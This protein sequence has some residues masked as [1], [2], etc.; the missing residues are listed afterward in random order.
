MSIQRW[1]QELTA[2]EALY[3]DP[4]GVWVTYDDH[5]A[6]SSGR[7]HDGYG[8]GAE[9]MRAACIAAVLAYAEER[10]TITKNPNASMD[11]TAALRVAADR[12]REV[13]P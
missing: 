11:I 2:T 5:I 1:Q 7:W 6:D 13:Q 10:L 12:L 9:A 4:E 3:E 8:D